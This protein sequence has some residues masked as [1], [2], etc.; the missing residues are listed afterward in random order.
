MN[1]F[2][3]QEFGFSPITSDMSEHM[4][5]VHQTGVLTDEPHISGGEIIDHYMTPLESTTTTTPPTPRSGHELVVIPRP[6]SATTEANSSYLE[7][8][9]HDL[10]TPVGA[11]LGLAIGAIVIGSIVAFK[12][13]LRSGR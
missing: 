4:T 13:K 2:G 6:Y 8:I 5:I 11:V 9:G 1:N 3:S 7:Q 12:R 10:E